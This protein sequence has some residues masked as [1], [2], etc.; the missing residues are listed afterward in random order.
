MAKN[1]RILKKA[2]MLGLV[3]AGL[4]LIYDYYKSLN[5]VTKYILDVTNVSSG[6]IYFMDILIDFALAFV[7]AYLIIFFVN[8]YSYKRN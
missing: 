8:K 3:G 7:F 1:K 2:L 6:S 4:L 5:P